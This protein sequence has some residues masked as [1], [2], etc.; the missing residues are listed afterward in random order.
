MA[1]TKYKIQLSPI[2]EEIFAEYRRADEKQNGQLLPHAVA[3][4]RRELK[5][6]EAL[7]P[8][9]KDVE[10]LW[11]HLREMHRQGKEWL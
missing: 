5:R 6:L 10:D 8:E 7:H 4:I 3:K 2:F 11:E 9:W 1:R